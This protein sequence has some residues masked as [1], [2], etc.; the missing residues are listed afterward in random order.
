MQISLAKP[1]IFDRA[2]KLF[3]VKETDPIWFTYGDTIHA[4]CGKMPPDYIIVHEEIHAEQQGHSN[5]GAKEWWRKYLADKE[6]RAHQEAE[7]YGAQLRW[8]RRQ[9]QY[10]DRNVQA[11][12][13][14]SI[15]N[16]LSGTM[17]G[18]CLTYAEAAKLVKAYADGTAIAE[19]EKHMPEVE[20]AAIE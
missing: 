2:V 11:R 1:P 18:K 6:F 16:N 14:H 9:K 4:P 19:I 17:Y 7:A 12:I 15:A 20:P 3:G 5:E 13:L 10:R 8:M